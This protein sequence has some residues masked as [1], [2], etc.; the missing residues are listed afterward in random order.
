MPKRRRTLPVHFSSIA[1]GLTGP[2]KLIPAIF[3]WVLLA[4][5]RAQENSIAPI[6]LPT[7]IQPTA[8]IPTTVSVKP[9]N[10]PRGTV[11]DNLGLRGGYGCGSG[12]S[13]SSTAIKPTTQCGALL[14]IGSLELEI[15]VMGPQAN[16]TQV[17][18][19]LSENLW[20]PLQTGSRRG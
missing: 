14:G 3:F 20:I 10:P 17:S 12:A 18:G 16:R 5:A 9:A 7:Q 15:G 11:Y 6:E 13:Y 2:T 8:S 19:Y 4:S 1:R